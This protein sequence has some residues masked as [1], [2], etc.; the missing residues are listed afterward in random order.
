MNC[1]VISDQDT[2]EVNWRN[3]FLGIYHSPDCAL[4]LI[5]LL[6]KLN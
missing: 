4:L 3:E 1:E 2:G 5:L 6:I